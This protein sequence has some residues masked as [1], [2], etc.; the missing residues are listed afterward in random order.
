MPD[1]SGGLSIVLRSDAALQGARIPGIC[2][3]L[4]GEVWIRPLSPAEQRLPIAV[5]EAVGA[6]GNLAVFELEVKAAAD[7]LLELDAST[8]PDMLA[9][10]R[11]HSA[12]MQLV[13]LRLLEL[14]AVRDAEERITAGNSLCESLTR[15][16]L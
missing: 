1:A 16:E 12:L 11:S 3:N 2:G 7:T 4:Y 15:L 9:G 6:Y 8:T 14:D 13:H 10:S 5:L